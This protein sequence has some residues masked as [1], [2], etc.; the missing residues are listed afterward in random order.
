MI[1]ENSL[2]SDSAPLLSGGKCLA[3]GQWKTG[4]EMFDAE[5]W[6]IY[7]DGEH[8]YRT[9]GD[10]MRRDAMRRG[11]AICQACRREQYFLTKHPMY[12]TTAD[13]FIRQLA[14]LRGGLRKKKQSRPLLAPINLFQ[15]FIAQGTRCALTGWQLEAKLCS[16]PLQ[17]TPLRVRPGPYSPRNICLVAR[18]IARFAHG[19]SAVEIQELADAIVKHGQEAREMALLA[20]IEGPDT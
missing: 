15:A 5:N 14:T 17:A 3:C 12:K 18:G 1:D 16:G 9:I 7:R 6:Q 8:V 20:S 19:A 10:H 4:E 11:E 13:F 2:L